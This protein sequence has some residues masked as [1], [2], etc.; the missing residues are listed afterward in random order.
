MAERKIAL[1]R[2]IN[3]GGHKKIKMADLRQMM[4]DAGF[5]TVKTV[6]ASG[7][8]AF[9]SDSDNLDEL[10]ATLETQIE[11]RFGFPVPVLVF[12]KQQITDLIGADP[13]EGIDVT[14]ATRL[15]VTFLPTPV[16]PNIDIP[17]EAPDGD[18]RILRVT[19]T[20][21]CSV[22][23]VDKTR[24]GDGMAIL[25]KEFGKGITTRNWNTVLKIAQL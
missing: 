4:D 7:N 2:G 3:V 21:V 15:Y 19:D 18:F 6:L 25:E 24:S 20:D 5:S 11:A 13:F 8:V 22:L 14:K 1:L 23:T 17:Y 16:T 9:D 12:P 10:K